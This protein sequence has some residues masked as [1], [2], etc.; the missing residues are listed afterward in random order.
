VLWQEKVRP[1]V[2]IELL[3]FSTMDEDYG[4]SD[5]RGSAHRTKLDI[6]RDMVQVPYY[7]VFDGEEVR[8]TMALHL[9]DG[10]YRRMTSV[11]DD[12]VRVPIPEIGLELRSWVGH[13]GGFEYCRLRWFTLDGVMIATHEE[14]NERLR[15]LLLAAGLD[16]NT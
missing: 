9:E 14:E 7:I 16:P 6:Y 1:I 15:A 4:I 11:I 3:S 5:S 13:Y 12:V 10:R 8:N 2:V